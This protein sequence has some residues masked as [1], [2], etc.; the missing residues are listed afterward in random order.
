MKK[1]ESSFRIAPELD[2]EPIEK[3][4][5]LRQLKAS[6][7]SGIE[8][9]RIRIVVVALDKAL[10]GIRVF[11]VREILK[12]PKITWLPCAPDYVAGV[13]AIRGE[14][15]AIINLK[16]LL[17]AGI[18]HLTAHSRIILVE[19]GELTAGLIVDEMLDIIEL[20][21]QAVL[22]VLE[23]S[24]LTTETFFDG[25]VNWNGRVISLLN[26][27]AILQGVVVDQV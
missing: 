27:E 14:V 26:I 25:N 11:S 7:S 22:P 19:A 5:I 24:R 18:G 8:E 9:T 1:D 6:N 15:Q 17:H 20:P 12:V 23:S 10:F 13:I 4:D 21:E 3:M 2:D 16:R